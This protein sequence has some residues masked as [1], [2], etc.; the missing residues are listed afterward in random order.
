MIHIF[1]KR[2]LLNSAFL[3][4]FLVGYGQQNDTSKQMVETEEFVPQWA[5]TVVW[6]QIFPERFR[7][8][9]P[10]NNPTVEDLKGA[11]P[12]ELPKEWQIHPW[13]SD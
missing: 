3:F 6:Y 5:K 4:L 1:N 10:A 11:D 12:Q 9:D 13:G 8:G 7:D 2:R